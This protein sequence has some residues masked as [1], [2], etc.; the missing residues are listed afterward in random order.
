MI[1]PSSSSSTID[2]LERATALQTQAMDEL[3]SVSKGELRSQRRRHAIIVGTVLTLVVGVVSYFASGIYALRYQY[4]ELFR[5]YDRMRREKV[6]GAGRH[7]YSMYQVVAAANYSAAYAML[8]LALVWRN[9][10]FQ[11]ANF[12]MQCV[13]YFEA[14][15]ARDPRAKLTAIH[16]AGDG[17]QSNFAK[18]LGDRGWASTGCAGGATTLEAKQRALVD[19]WN[20]SKDAGNPWYYLLPQPVDDGGRRAF[21]SMPMIAELYAADATTHGTDSACNANEF[22]QSRIGLLFSGGLCHVAFT[23][24]ARDESAADIFNKYFEVTAAPAVLPSCRG[25]AA[26]GATQGAMSGA[27]TGLMLVGMIPGLGPEA[28]AGVEAAAA[29]RMAFGKALAAIAF[30][31]GAAAVGGIT[32]ANAARERCQ[33]QSGNT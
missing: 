10:D 27:M 21:L 19:N 2:A 9:L 1:A 32:S 33:Q 3:A 30:G 22:S 11:G 23:E 8:N 7:N 26:A 25:A 24:T 31:G 5:W 15:A 18:L 17:T 29:A 16:W 28:K 13:T 12:L 14:K 6:Q 4:P 20:A